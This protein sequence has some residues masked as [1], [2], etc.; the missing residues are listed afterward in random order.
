MQGFAQRYI[1]DSI[2]SLFGS[3]IKENI[4][5]FMSFADD[6]EPPVLTALREAGI[7]CQKYFKLNNSA[8]Y[9][10]REEFTE[11]YWN[12]T[13]KKFKAFKTEL[14]KIESRSLVLTLE[15]LGK[16]K[17]L[18][19]AIKNLERNIK[20]LLDRLEE[21]KKKKELFIQHQSIVDRNK[22]YT[23]TTQEQIMTQRD[24]SDWTTNCNECKVTCHDYCLMYFDK[25]KFTCEVMKNLYCT[26]CPNKCYWTMHENQ[27]FIY[28]STMRTGTR[29]IEDMKKTYEAALQKKL[30]TE[31]M[32]KEM[33]N[34]ISDVENAAVELY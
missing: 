12:M 11:L 9:A 18:E 23:V 28:E 30:T 8:L 15:V 20:I 7:P 31:E 6:Q 5:M 3:D 4:C 29:D 17:E 22:N 27:Q 32:I 26:A 1:F 19:I 33:E 2:L 25:G 21:L 24:T 13:K 14:A 34:E 16:R 10:E